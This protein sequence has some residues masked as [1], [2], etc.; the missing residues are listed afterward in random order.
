MEYNITKRTFEALNYP[1]GSEERI[2]LNMNSVTSEYMTSYKYSV[3]SDIC[4]FSFKTK[5]EAESFIK[6][7]E[8][9]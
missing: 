7:Q 3:S 9:N 4:D 6:D 1:K 5:K 8:M 2:R